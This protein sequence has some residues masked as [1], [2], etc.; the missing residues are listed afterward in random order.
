[1]IIPAGHPATSA[2]PQGRRPGRHAL[3]AGLA[4]AFTALLVP[5]AWAWVYTEIVDFNLTETTKTYGSYTISSSGDGA[6][7]YRWLDDPD[8]TTVISGN[9]C[10]DL[11]LYGKREIPAHNTSYHKLFQGNPGLCFV[12]RGRVAYGAGSMYHHDGRLRR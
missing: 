6:A 3:T 5:V 9:N 8:H 7:H 1:M 11:A 10:I 4:L 12:L 2:C